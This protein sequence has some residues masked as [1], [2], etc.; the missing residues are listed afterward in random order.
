MNT[1]LP[2]GIHP[3]TEEGYNVAGVVGVRSLALLGAR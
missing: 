3:G 1:M 2:A